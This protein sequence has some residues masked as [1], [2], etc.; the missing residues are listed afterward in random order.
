MHE[1]VFNR[2]IHS[3]IDIFLE[4]HSL[5]TGNHGERW[6]E[7]MRVNTKEISYIKTQKTSKMTL[8]GLQ[9]L[10]SALRKVITF[11]VLIS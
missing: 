10:V 5:N 4:N 8:L 9:S 11:K 3:F 7:E 1:G 2:E 6:M